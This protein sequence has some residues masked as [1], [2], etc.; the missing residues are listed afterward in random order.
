[1]A[2]VSFWKMREFLCVNFWMPKTSKMI[3]ELDRFL[4]VL[5][6][7]NTFDFTDQVAD[8]FW[9]NFGFLFKNRS[10]RFQRVQFVYFDKV[11]LRKAFLYPFPHVFQSSDFVGYLGESFAIKIIRNLFEKL[12][13]CIFILNFAFKCRNTL[14]SYI[15]APWRFE[16]QVDSNLLLVF[17]IAKTAS[18]NPEDVS[19]SLDDRQLLKF[20]C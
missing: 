6:I 8:G 13:V 4:R 17:K 1:M 10:E 2:N 7:H 9:F 16:V 19:F 15:Q 3:S 18:V 5:L 14:I 20:L 11:K 12:R